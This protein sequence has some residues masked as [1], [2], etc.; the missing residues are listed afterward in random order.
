MTKLTQTQQ[1]AASAISKLGNLGF[2]VGLRSQH[3]PYIMSHLDQGT[4]LGVDW[5]EIIS[6]NYIDNHGYGRYVLDKLKEQYPLV[7]HGVSMNIGSSDPLN[8]EY[9]SKLKTLSEFVKPQLIS[10]H[11]CWTG[12]AGLNSHDLLPMP[13]TDESLQHVIRRI[14]QVQDFLERPLVLENPSTYLEF[15]HSTLTESEFFCELVKATGCGMLLDV[16]NVFV[17]GFNHGF[18]AEQFIHELPHEHIVQIHL[19]GPSDCGD[20]LIDTHDQPVP[21]K[22]WQLYQLAQSLTGGASTLLEWDANIPSFPELV[23]ELNK[24]KLVLEGHI[25]QQDTVSKTNAISTPIVNE[26][27]ELL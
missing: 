27:A 16:N 25:P 20:C 13:L 22:V 21:E 10:D 18:N 17:S 24:A 26:R 23:E 19:A 5:F 6:E 11:L 2:G 9:L 8:F 14:D 7:M 3:Y 12:L 1:F 4:P 15:Q